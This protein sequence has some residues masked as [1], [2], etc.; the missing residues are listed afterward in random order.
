[1]SRERLDVLLAAYSAER[2]DDSQTVTSMF[3][4]LTAAIGLVTIIGFALVNHDSIPSWLIALAPLLPVPFVA[5]GALLANV[6]Q[7]RG[8]VIDNYE[9]EIRHLLRNHDHPENLVPYGHTLL[10]ER[11]WRAPI[12]QIVLMI[13]FLAY[14]GGYIAVLIEC[15][16]Y[17]KA[18]ENTLAL[19][20]LI[21]ASLATAILLGLFGASLK[22]EAQLRRGLRD[23]ANDE[24]DS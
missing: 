3:G 5:F 24:H 14:F 17:S 8:R 2:A 13:S 1:M 22:P 10:D 19:V 4:L 18:Q 21:S 9:R 12:A 7:L 16:R 11:I 23:L 20:G 6:A 15:F